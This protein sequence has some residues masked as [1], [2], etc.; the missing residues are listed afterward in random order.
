MTRTEARLADALDAAARAL[1]EDTLRPLLVVQRQRRRAAWTAPAAAAASLL[2]VVGI[3]A[4]VAG[5]LP[6]SG[7]LS[8]GPPPRYYVEADAHGDRPVVRSTA[9]GEV[10]DTVPVPHVSDLLGTYLVAATS[11]GVFFTA[12]PAATGVRIYRFRLTS[13][14][15]VSAL[16]TVPGRP[17]GSLLA[18]QAMAASPDG[19]RVAIAF[20]PAI[21]SGSVSCDPSGGCP[22][23]ISIGGDSQIDVVDTATG[24]VSVW[25]GGTGQSY[26]FSVVNLSWTAPGKELVYYGQ[27]CPQ[28]SS[29]T[30]SG[31]STPSSSSTQSSSSPPSSSSTQQ[32][33][34]TQQNTITATVTACVTGSGG[35]KAEVWALDPAARGG[36]L[37]SGRHLFSLSAAFPYLP[38]VL[39]SPDGTTLTAVALTGPVNRAGTPEH[40]SVEQI[41]VATRKRSGVLYSQD[42]GRAVANGGLAYMY[43]VTLSM[44]AA[45]QHWILS[46]SFCDTNGSCRGGLNGW[47]DNGRLV[48]LQPAGGSV[49]SEAW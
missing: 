31:S 40:L 49:A 11:N 1:R 17:L 24:A 38:Q 28:S 30:Q 41:S 32:V 34:V 2:L 47:I 13:A 15:Q 19:S 35:A 3:A 42:L 8:S 25:Q 5:Y 12:V 16:V 22:A 27:W 48:P 9:T 33:T 10:T 45:G 21:N 14:G 23:G 7:R 36:L 4:I 26:S 37:T 43:P 44:D 46:G 20:V 29:S 39:I 6:G 18:L